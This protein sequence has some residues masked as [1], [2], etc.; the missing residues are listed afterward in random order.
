MLLLLP[1]LLLLLLLLLLFRGNSDW[2]RLCPWNHFLLGFC[3]IDRGGARE[4]FIVPTGRKGR[5]ENRLKSFITCEPRRAAFPEGV[6]RLI[7]NATRPDYVCK[8]SVLLSNGFSQDTLSKEEAGSAAQFIEYLFIR[9]SVAV[10]GY[11]TT[12]SRSERSWQWNIRRT[13]NEI[14]NEFLWTK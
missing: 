4:T 5:T 1:L 2:G 6:P 10:S 12:V 8:G 14:L 13:Y 9:F 7:E 3:P 11:C